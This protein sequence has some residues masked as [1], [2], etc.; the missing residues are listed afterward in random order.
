MAEINQHFLVVGNYSLCG[1]CGHLDLWIPLANYHILISGL[2]EIQI[3]SMRKTNYKHL[4][5]EADS[6]SFL[7]TPGETSAL[8]HRI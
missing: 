8:P 6:L 1:M 3:I 4:Q 5:A 2:K 7:L